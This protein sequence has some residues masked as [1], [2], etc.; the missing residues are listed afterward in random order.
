[1]Y[2]YIYY[3]YHFLARVGYL[4]IIARQRLVAR[5]GLGEYNYPAYIS[6]S[7]VPGSCLAD[8]VIKIHLPIDYHGIDKVQYL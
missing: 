8:P 1:M 5:G 3:I 7:K 4:L 2:Q 6:T